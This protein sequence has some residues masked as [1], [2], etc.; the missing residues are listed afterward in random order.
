MKKP[1]IKKKIIIPAV[2]LLV[3]AGAGVYA[4]QAVSGTPEFK[5]VETYAAETTDLVNAV[6]VTGVVESAN[7]TNIY[8]RLTYP[9]R[10]V[11]VE[12]GD[13]VREGDVLAQLDTAALEATIAQ[14]QASL[15]AAQA[16][17]NHT[18]Q[19]AQKDL[20]S[21]PEDVEYE[22]DISIETAESAVRT[23]ENNLRAQE[24]KAADLRQ[25]LR[26]LRDDKLQVPDST[27]YDEYIE[28]KKKELVQTEIAMENA[29]LT[30]EEAQ[31]N[32][33]TQK[34]QKGRKSYQSA[35][36]ARDGVT[37]AELNAN[38]NDQYIAIQRLQQDLA[39]ATVKAPVSGTVTAVYA[40]EGAPG[41]GLLF[42]I[43][44]TGHLKVTTKIKEYDIGTVKEGLP[45]TIKTD[46]TGADEFHGTLTRIF[47]TAQKDASGK[48]LDTTNV[49]FPA[50][51]MV[52]SGSA[53]R[54][55]MNARLSIITGEK[56][57]VLTV[58]FEAIG[59][60]ENGETFVFVMQPQEDGTG[61]ARKV[62][63]TAGMET[64]FFSE[65]T[66]GGLKEGDLVITSA[67][68]IEDGMQVVQMDEAALQQAV[69]A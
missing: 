18:V 41:S 34:E 29:A 43:E 51:I 22:Y 66:G 47:P 52:D 3:I 64:D 59:A 25:E 44:D 49:E 32:L 2:I 24:H 21:N 60:D 68:G 14:N 40:T 10:T 67:Q 16:K 58:P 42:V 35:E 19:M 15:S 48:T 8:T 13:A 5:T 62:M 7:V 37:S 27:T 55:G 53:L 17:A 61:I 30:L 38:F 9:I 36:S 57:G 69:M 20:E 28:E 4:V 45:V 39:D 33:Q 12:V 6:S 63:V 54:I 46:A 56:K 11:N 26:D 65:I 50:E 23:A 1:K 31:Q